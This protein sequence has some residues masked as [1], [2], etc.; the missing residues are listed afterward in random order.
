MAYSRHSRL[1]YQINEWKNNAN[2]LSGHL[3][4]FVLSL[5]SRQPCEANVLYAKRKKK[6]SDSKVGSTI[7]QGTGKA[8]HKFHRNQPSPTHHSCKVSPAGQVTAA[9]LHTEKLCSPNHPIKENF[10]TWNQSE[11]N[12]FLAWKVE[13]IFTQK[14]ILYLQLRCLSLSR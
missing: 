5:S 1:L 7:K 10:A 4:S 14:S 3:D 13:T 11:R 6:S 8:G 12:L 9:S 2:I